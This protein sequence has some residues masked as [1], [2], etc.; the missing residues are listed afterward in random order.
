[1]FL[2]KIRKKF[3]WYDLRKEGAKWVKKNLGSEWVDD[4][5]EKHDKINQGIPIGGY[6]ETVVFLEMI[7]RIK[8]EI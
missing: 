4:F 2:S 6:A 7:E 3:G 8:A 1:M 5:L